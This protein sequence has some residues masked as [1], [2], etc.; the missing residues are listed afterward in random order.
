MN[1]FNYQYRIKSY[2]L[3]ILTI[4]ISLGLFS[5]NGAH[6]EPD[7][8]SDIL[9]F[10]IAVP[11]TDLGSRADDQGH[12]EV[13]S[14]NPDMEDF[15]NPNDIAIFMFLGDEDNAPKIGWWTIL[16]Q[17]E[18][19]E[20]SITGYGSEYV[21]SIKLNR[22]TL[23]LLKPGLE[24]GPNSNDMVILRL[25]VLANQKASKKSTMENKYVGYDSISTY[26]ALVDKA[27][28][29]S[30][31]L[32]TNF[33]PSGGEF[34]GAI[35]MFGSMLSEVS[36]RELYYS[37]PDEIIDLG[38]LELLRS[39]VKVRLK[40]ETVKVNGYPK[41]SPYDNGVPPTTTTGTTNSGL[42]YYYRKLFNVPYDAINYVNGQQVHNINLCTEGNDKQSYVGNVAPTDMSAEGILY[43]TYC[44]EQKIDP[45]EQ[46]KSP[47]FTFYYKESEEAEKWES[48]NVYLEGSE[49]NG[50]TDYRGLIRNH[51]YTIAITNQT[52]RSDSNGIVANVI[53]EEW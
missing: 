26:K 14:D 35:P 52:S 32:G 2:Q 10:R 11:Y 45:K 19:P 16:K 41:V 30:T 39:L 36:A 1:L 21:I 50:V 37:R 25:A 12:D 23:S 3:W 20:T 43:T 44:P 17:N 4:W 15:I 33:Y 46:S 29:N 48:K 13:D 22:T 40:D 31:S 38:N 42:S 51:V 7:E 24:I 49:L 6:N 47:F 18:Y 5:C 8:V 53:D 27:S 28:G 9:T 34:T